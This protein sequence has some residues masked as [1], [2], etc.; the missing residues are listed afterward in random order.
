MTYCYSK[1][2]APPA[3]PVPLFCWEG[4]SWAETQPVPSQNTLPCSVTALGVPLHPQAPV[5]GVLTA[6]SAP[7][8]A[9][10][11]ACNSFLGK[12]SWCLTSTGFVI[13]ETSSEQG[14]LSQ[15]IPFL[16]NV[17]K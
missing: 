14:F 11:D 10:L 16:G 8:M 17:L 13:L 1:A 9:V 4:T 7:A 6:A 2:P 5:S 12:S 15:I 3:V